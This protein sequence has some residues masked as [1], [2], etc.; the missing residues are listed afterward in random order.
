MRKLEL[1]DIA[2]YL[3]YGVLVT[4]DGWDN[5]LK[6]VAD[7]YELDTYEMSIN[8]VLELQP[9]LILHPISDLT[10]E[11]EIN[12]E[13]FVPLDK[14]GWNSYSHIKDGY[15]MTG[16]A[17]SY[18]EKLISWHFDVFGLIP[19]GLAYDINTLEDNT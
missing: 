18:I 11:I 1:K 7:R 4:M 3:P 13:K 6:L 15:D 2:P 9:K 19:E 16:I 5:Y 14:L 12:G 8:L 17:Y 10:K